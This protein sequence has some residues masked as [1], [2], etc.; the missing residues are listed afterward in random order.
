MD[1]A[2]SE[3]LCGGDLIW[4]EKRS[5]SCASNVVRHQ[6][7]LYVINTNRRNQLRSILKIPDTAAKAIVELR[8]R[9]GLPYTIQHLGELIS[10]D[11]R[12]SML[13]KLMLA[14]RWQPI[15]APARQHE[16]H[17][18]RVPLASS[19]S[20]SEFPPLSASLGDR[21]R[22]LSSNHETQRALPD[23]HSPEVPGNAV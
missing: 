12:P 2:V 10:A 13:T 1:P 6:E 15:N 23:N 3:L 22:S 20:D 21:S 7:L 5:F 19:L 16:S 11:F 18:T 17:R 9:G 8:R 4:T 14:S